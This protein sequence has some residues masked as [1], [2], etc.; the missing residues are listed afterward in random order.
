MSHRPGTER[1]RIFSFGNRNV[2]PQQYFFCVVSQILSNRC[3]GSLQSSVFVWTS[4]RW[5]S[6]FTLQELVV[7]SVYNHFTCMYFFASDPCCFVF[8]ISF[9]LCRRQRSETDRDCFRSLPVSLFLPI[10]G[11]RCCLWIFDEE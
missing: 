7:V 10:C 1:L 8:Q 4:E 5:S 3:T 9:L 11:E 2:V 6:G